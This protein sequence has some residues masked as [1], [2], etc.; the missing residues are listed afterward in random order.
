M[1]V[2]NSYMEPVGEMVIGERQRATTPTLRCSGE[3]LCLWPGVVERFPTW[4]SWLGC[5]RVV[6]LLFR[7]RARVSERQRNRD[8]KNFVKKQERKVT[9]DEWQ[10]LWVETKK[11]QW[12]KML[13]PDI[14]R[15]MT[16][17]RQ[18]EVG[19]HKSTCLKRSQDTGLFRA[20]RRSGP[21]TSGVYT[22]GWSTGR[23]G[24]SDW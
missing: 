15:W 24:K 23:S 17:S 5:P 12:T 13:I 11:A 9:F 14:R 19:F 8:N 2:V 6:H 16:A 4:W 22:I 18:K 21:I 20:L 10:K 3:Q 1:S 7:E